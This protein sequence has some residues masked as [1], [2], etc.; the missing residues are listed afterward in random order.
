MH[1]TESTSKRLL[2][3]FGI[4]SAVGGSAASPDE[5][6]A[7]LDELGGDAFI[8][9]EVPVSGRGKLGLVHRVNSREDCARIS[10][11]LLDQVV[12]GYHTR[13]L[14]VEAP[15][16][17]V[18]REVYVAVS[19]DGALGV[20]VLLVNPSGGADIESAV[21]R[22]A[23]L[24]NKPLVAGQTPQ[25]SEIL[26]WLDREELG[27]G[28]AGVARA[29]QGAITMFFQL[30]ALLV[31]INPLIVSG[32]G[33][34]AAD[35]KVELDNNA[36]FRRLIEFHD[37]D[38]DDDLP[39][40]L[41]ELDGSIALLG[42]GAGITL[43]TMDALA[44]EGLAAANY[45]ELAGG[46]SADVVAT[47]VSSVGSWAIGRGGVSALVVVGSLVAT[48]LQG[49]VEGLQRALAS[50]PALASLPILVHMHASGAAA[51]PLDE[52]GA[53]AL[54]RGTSVSWAESIPAVVALA[55]N[56][57]NGGRQ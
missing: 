53:A 1:L 17:R 25:L 8:K 40:G 29:V 52:A 50:T 19:I 33:V 48:P 31:E 55:R 4:V 10:G 51:R 13:T 42:L 34:I 14:R 15:V 39:R 36:T 54:L 30:E 7:L 12:S 11:Q 16:E 38:C 2:A 20:P 46:S 22:A 27:Q 44:A 45:C 57:T 35:C 18:D 24:L 26:G 21:D 28:W 56:L 5:A 32:S 37:D 6:V 47:M 9:S 43:T 3:K 49:V 41:V 23:T